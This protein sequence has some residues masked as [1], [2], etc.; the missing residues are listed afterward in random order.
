MNKSKATRPVWLPKRVYP[1]GNLYRYISPD[2][3]YYRLGRIDAGQVKILSE[4]KRVINEIKDE[5]ESSSKRSFRNMVKGYRQSPMFT[6][7]APRTQ[8]D[9]VRHLD[10]LSDLF[11][12]RDVRSITSPMIDNIHEAFT[13]K[14][15]AVTAN[16]H[17]ASLSRVFTWGKRKGWVLNDPSKGIAVKNKERPRDRYISDLELT[18]LIEQA[19]P[20]LKTMILI[21]YLCAARFSDV[22]TLT[23]AQISEEG[24]YIR[25]GK[26]GKKQ[27]KT[28]SKAL[29][30]AVRIQKKTI[31]VGSHYLFPGRNDRPGYPEHI[32]KSTMEV[33]FRKARKEA[34]EYAQ[35][36][37]LKYKPDFTFHD[38]KAKGISDYE[39]NKQEFS[40]HKTAAQVDVY[41]RKVKRVRA[42]ERK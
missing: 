10:T 8:A 18:L 40:G 4:Y 14:R 28:W 24:I 1:A 37:E 3:K 22:L 9:Y 17:F 16:R 32:A 42:L 30:E 20:A 15:G 19:P 36:Y 34:F 29:K 33:N 7:L 23:M 35:K 38:L 41:D 25:Q 5:K 6:E 27:V 21:S 12:T 31:P 13:V 39:G 2:G 26:T 11:G